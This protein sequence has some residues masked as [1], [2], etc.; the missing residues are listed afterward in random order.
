MPFSGFDEIS[1]IAIL[2]KEYGYA[3]KH[4]FSIEFGLGQ[5]YKATIYTAKKTI[6]NIYLN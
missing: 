3:I 6:K 4:H 1:R 5:K 2:I